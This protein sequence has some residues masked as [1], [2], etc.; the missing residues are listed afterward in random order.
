MILS[1]TDHSACEISS[2]MSQVH[3]VALKRSSWIRRPT[4]LP[5]TARALRSRPRATLRHRR[6]SERL[7]DRYR[8]GGR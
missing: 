5:L 8:P 6:R 3:A 7:V 2:K 1:L 4:L